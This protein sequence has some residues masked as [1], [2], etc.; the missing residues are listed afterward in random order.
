MENHD[1]NLSSMQLQRENELLRNENA[2]LKLTLNSLEDLRKDEQSFRQ[3][4]DNLSDQVAHIMNLDPFGV[5]YISPSF[6]QIWKMPIE[7]LLEN[8]NAFIDRIHPEDRS[9]LTEYMQL[10]NSGIESSVEYRLLFD[11]GSIR[12]IKD[13]ASPV[14]DSSGKVYRATGIAEDIT[15][16]KLALEK[17][18]ISEMNF[19]SIAEAM[20]QIVWSTLP[21]GHHDY[22]NMHWYEFTGMPIG[23]LYGE[24]WNAMFHPDDQARVWKTWKHS[25][26][27]GEPYEIEYRLRAADKTFRWTLGRALPLRN[28]NGEIVRWMGTF[29]DIQYLR[30]RE[31][32]LKFLIES[33]RKEQVLREHFV[34]ALSHD[35]RTPLL[36]V[37]MSAELLAKR[38]SLDPNT[39]RFT[40]MILKHIERAD[41]MIRDL[42]DANLIKVGE[43]L[44]LTIEFCDLTE[45]VEST[46]EELRVALCDRFEFFGPKKLSGFW[47]SS[48]LRR[49]IENLC[50]N[51]VKYGAPDTPIQVFI[52][53]KSECMHLLVRNQGE[54]I[55]LHD[56]DKLF[57]MFSRTD[58][59]QSSGQIGWGLG[60]TLVKGLA[61]AHGGEVK[62]ESSFEN[63][64]VFSVKLP[65]DCRGFVGEGFSDMR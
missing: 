62:V 40:S 1:L 4:F 38:N 27:T 55:A 45:I 31:E 51:A 3:L 50:S 29:T 52:D 34:T 47:S 36:A 63:G 11:D 33:L 25:L 32:A 64:T 65:L 24:G 28:E 30:N 59:A 10:Q 60:L 42:L 20:P 41:V 9:K 23:S 17:L 18:R 19:R 39:Q 57:E 5:G 21:D 61:T 37:K 46:L 14:K 16:S 2:A 8:P 6:K 44:P 49:I 35:L 56:Q 54:P 53:Q 22:Y 26:A 13:R 7:A 43:R 58:S 48:G 15:E 12:W